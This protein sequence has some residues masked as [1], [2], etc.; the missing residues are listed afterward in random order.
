MSPPACG[1]CCTKLEQFGVHFGDTVILENVNL[2]LHCGELTALIGP[3][4]AGKTTLLRA[5]LGEVPHSGGMRFLAASGAHRPPRFGYVPQTLEFDTGAPLSVADLFAGA[6]ARWPAWLGHTAAL[7][8]RASAALAR[9]QAAHLLLRRVGDLSGGELQRVLLALALEPLPDLLLLDEPVTGV[10]ATGREQFYALICALRRDFDLSILLVAHD[11]D[12][13][14]RHA[15]RFVLLDRRL[16]AAGT[17]AEV[18]AHPDCVLRFGHIIPDP[19]QR[20]H[21]GVQPRAEQ[22][23]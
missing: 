4:G 9:V 14:A 19:Q 17:P 13:V 20:H 2:H 1:S 12:L 18:L 23:A 15:D 16:L 6:L 7:R 5:L 3:N 8:T 10:D 11:L 21:H 22:H